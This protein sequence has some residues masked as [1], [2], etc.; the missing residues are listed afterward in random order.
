MQRAPAKAQEETSGL[1]LS[2]A[3]RS[4]ARALVWGFDPANWEGDADRQGAQDR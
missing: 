4:A 3:L 2:A 1:E